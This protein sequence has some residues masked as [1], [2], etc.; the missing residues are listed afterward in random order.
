MPFVWELPYGTRKDLPELTLTMHYYSAD[1]KQRFVIL[2]GQRHIEGDAL[3]NGVSVV[4]IR[5]D[6]VVLRTAAP[7]LVAAV[8]VE[9]GQRVTRGQEIAVLESMK[10][11]TTATSTVDGVVTA[12]FEVALTAGELRRAL[13]SGGG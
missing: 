13:G 11:V 3:D 5:Q 6:G 12:Y 9:P 8:L 7:A 2:D 10:M 4:S 1:P